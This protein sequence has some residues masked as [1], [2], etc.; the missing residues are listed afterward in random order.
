MKELRCKKCGKL[1]AKGSG[2]VEIKCN[3]CKTVTRFSKWDDMKPT[4]HKFP[5]VVNIETY[6][7]EI[8]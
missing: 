4:K 8:D 7:I 6:N 3:R 5:D 1:L 2:E